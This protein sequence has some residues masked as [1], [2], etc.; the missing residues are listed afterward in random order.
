[1]CPAHMLAHFTKRSN[2]FVVRVGLYGVANSGKNEFLMDT[3]HENCH[4]RNLIKNHRI[5]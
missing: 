5:F 3:F 1:M 2:I 4:E